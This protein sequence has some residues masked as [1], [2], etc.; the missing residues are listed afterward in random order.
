MATGCPAIVSDIE[1]F[2]EIAGDAAVYVPAT[3]H[4]SKSKIT[5]IVPDN[6]RPIVTPF[7]P[8]VRKLHG[9]WPPLSIIFGQDFKV[10]L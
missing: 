3:A 10:S 1:V 2:H 6:L 8:Q 7:L 9:H 5:I 4:N